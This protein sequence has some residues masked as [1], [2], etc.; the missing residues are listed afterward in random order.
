MLDQILEHPLVWTEIE[1]GIRRAVLHRFPYCVFYGLEPER[2][3]VFAVLHHSRDP[4]NW[5]GRR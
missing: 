2:I 5:P 3:E 4:A 1:P